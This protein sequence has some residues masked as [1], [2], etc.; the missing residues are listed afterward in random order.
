MVGRY[1]VIAADAEVVPDLLRRYAERSK[2]RVHP[3]FALRE[4]FDVALDGSERGFIGLPPDGPGDAHQDGIATADRA[5]GV[6]GHDDHVVAVDLAVPVAD[7]ALNRSDLPDVAFKVP[8]HASRLDALVLAVD[9]GDERSNS[10][11]SPLGSDDLRQPDGRADDS[12]LV[13]EPGLLVLV[14]GITSFVTSALQQ[15]DAL[16][17]CHVIESGQPR[18][19][20]DSAGNRPWILLCC[21]N[22]LVDLRA[23]DAESALCRLSDN[24]CPHVFGV[25]IENLFHDYLSRRHSASTST[26][27]AAGRLR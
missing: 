23:G 24:V 11:V 26:P 6:A 10:A 22:L 25:I 15:V 18:H 9:L 27:K 12:F 14:V 20:G 4:R 1:L 2:A 8:K 17:G 5:C 19:I 16:L 13:G 21:R 3:R 7:A